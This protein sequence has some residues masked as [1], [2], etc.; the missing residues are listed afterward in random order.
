MGGKTDLTKYV[1][2]LPMLEAWDHTY[3]TSEVLKHKPKVLGT[4]FNL[5]LEKSLKFKEK[6]LADLANKKLPKVLAV[7]W[8]A[9]NNR[10][11]NG[12]PADI[13]F[14]NHS[15]GGVS[16]KNGSTII[17]NLGTEDFDAYVQR[18]K[19][20]DLFRHLAPNEFSN[21]LNKVK[22]DLMNSLS[23]G[24][25]WTDYG[26]YTI[27]KIDNQ[28]FK[29]V[30]GKSSKI[31][32]YQEVIQDYQIKNQKNKKKPGGVYRVF[33]DYYQ[34]NK[35]NYVVER[36]A[37]YKVLYPKIENLLKEVVFNDPIK[38]SRLGGFTEKPY[39]VC[40]MI[41]NK[42]FYVPSFHQ[43][44]DNIVVKIFDKD[45]ETN[46]GS[47]FEIGCEVKLKNSINFARL[48]FYVCYNSGT[49]NRGPVI[50]LQ[51]LQGKENL[52]IEIG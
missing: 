21:L 5:N 28:K 6:I 47:G 1:T 17:G 31:I 9:N 4:E 34:K 16:V 52:W 22:A 26:K 11:D 38:L 46:F 12:S 36:K 30:Y 41:A 44:K 33:G 8:Q 27:T 20:I 49:F 40:D 10:N 42:L 32:T 29:I 15:I 37:L 19:G 7:S 13:V 51:N 43:V 3:E 2:E 45:K 18:P 23:N 24:E 14:Q 39:Y 48:D 25:T 50:K 35:I